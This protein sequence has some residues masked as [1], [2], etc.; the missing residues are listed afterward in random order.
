M[1]AALEHGAE[2]SGKF[3]R[4][5][6]FVFIVDSRECTAIDYQE[7]CPK[8]FHLSAKKDTLSEDS[9]KS[10]CRIFQKSVVKKRKIKLSRKFPDIFQDG[11]RKECP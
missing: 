4:R 5:K 10:F 9:L 2:K 6:V 1:N 3:C 8:E 11:K 7:F